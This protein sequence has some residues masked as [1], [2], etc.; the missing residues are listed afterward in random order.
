MCEDREHLVRCGLERVG[1]GQVNR[2][3]QPRRVRVGVGN[4]GAEGCYL[5]LTARETPRPEFRIT[6]RVP[7]SVRAD[8]RRHV[9]GGFQVVL[10]AMELQ[11]N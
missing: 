8:P 2:A 10:R 1:N 9:L 4:V 5:K 7:C 3:P 11:K 6:D